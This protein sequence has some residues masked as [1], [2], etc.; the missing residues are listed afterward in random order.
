MFTI[1]HCFKCN[2]K[3][4]EIFTCSSGRMTVLKAKAMEPMAPMASNTPV[5]FDSWM[6]KSLGGLCLP[7]MSS[8]L[9]I[10]LLSNANTFQ[11]LSKGV[12]S[13]RRNWWPRCVQHWPKSSASC[14]YENICWQAVAFAN[15][16][17]ILCFEVDTLVVTGQDT[18]N[19]LIERK[20]QV[21]ALWHH[22][23]LRRQNCLLRRTHFLVYE[24]QQMIAQNMLA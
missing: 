11:K 10:S 19:G 2:E 23:E 12:M 16:R 18:R 21:T 9:Q 20:D 22:Q 14:R 3:S 5:G 15:R 17:A 24:K 13:L 7:A 1:I 8:Q 6:P 4:Q